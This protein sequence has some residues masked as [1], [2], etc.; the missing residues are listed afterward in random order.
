[1]RRWWLIIALLLSVGVNAGILA[2]LATRRMTRPERQP[3][4]PREEPAPLGPEEGGPDAGGPP[5]A[6]RLADR[7]GLEGEPRRRFLA[8][9]QSFFEQ[10][11]RIRLHMAETQREVRRELMSPEP[12]RQKI[13]A[14]LQDSARD[15]LSL[16]Q[17]LAKNVVE[18][19][20]IL[21]PEQE[22]EFLRI[23]AS[24]RPQAGG[25]GPRPGRRPG[26]PPWRQGGR[27]GDRRPPRDRFPEEEGPPPED[28]P[29]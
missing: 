12:D 8:L 16:E 14:L 4:P 29:P 26:P 3:P 22:E 24:L 6:S 25:F 21:D 20:E 18:S 27:N 28:G 19:R 23:V 9:Q 13:D 1:V 17:A 10:T 15:F 11:V 5:R 2:A 7:L